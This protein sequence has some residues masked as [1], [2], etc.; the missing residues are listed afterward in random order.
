[1]NKK[2]KVALD[3]DGVIANTG[4]IIEKELYTRGYKAHYETYKPVIFGLDDSEN[5]LNEIV[6]DIFYNKMDQILPYDEHLHNIMK[7]IDI[8]TDISIV[9]ARRAEFNDVTRQWCKKYFP[10]V[11]VDIVHLRSSE[12]SQYIKNNGFLCFVEDRLRTANEA[13]A[14]GI[15][16]FLINRRWNVGRRTH[17]NVVRVSEFSTFQSLLASNLIPPFYTPKKSKNKDLLGC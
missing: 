10:D 16:T 9:T 17:K 5:L 2:Y 15:N 3:M 12:K 13:A 1:M 6:D 8:N 11:K 14:L 7:E 4:D